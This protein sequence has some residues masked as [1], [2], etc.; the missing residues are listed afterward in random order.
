[1]GVS[2]VN[3]INKIQYFDRFIDKCHWFVAERARET[4]S[5]LNL[6]WNTKW[7]WKPVLRL[8]LGEKIV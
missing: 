7:K 3:N 1:M 6:E 8:R 5:V 4:P 2:S